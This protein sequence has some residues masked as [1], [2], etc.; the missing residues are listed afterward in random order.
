MYIRFVTCTKTRLFDLAKNAASLAH[1]GY[2]VND[3]GLVV[4][5]RCW[6]KHAPVTESSRTST[7]SHRE[8]QQYDS[9]CLSASSALV[10]FVQCV[11]VV[12]KVDESA[13]S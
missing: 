6:W 7:G 3:M 8:Y 10:C 4:F 5:A 13:A 1:H 11:V 12:L 2:V 9:Y